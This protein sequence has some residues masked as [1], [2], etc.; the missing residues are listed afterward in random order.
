M[1]EARPAVDREP[2]EQRPKKKEK[3][4]GEELTEPYL[5]R[6]FKTHNPVYVFGSVLL[7]LGFFILS[8]TLPGGI[9]DT[10]TILGLILLQHLFEIGLIVLGLWLI[11]HHEQVEDGRL[12]L[13]VES[14]LL[15]DGTFLT[16]DYFYRASGDSFQV[17][18]LVAAVVLMQINA[19]KVVAMFHLLKIH[20]ARAH[21]FFI[22]L[23]FGLLFGLPVMLTVRWVWDGAI[24]AWGLYACWTVF[25]I[26]AAG[27]GIWPHAARPE[28]DA[29][30]EDTRPARRRDKE[31]DSDADLE[32]E[33]HV[34]EHLIQTLVVCMY[35]SLFA[36]LMA[37]GWVSDEPFYWRFLSPM[38]IAFGLAKSALLPGF[39]D[40]RWFRI[41]QV[42]MP[43]IAVLL[44]FP[45]SDPSSADAT[46][47]MITFKLTLVAAAFAYI[48]DFVRYRAMGFAT[49]A[50]VTV[51]LL[52]L[53][54]RWS[55]V[56]DK[57]EWMRWV[58]PFSWL[59]DDPIVY[60][61]TFVGGSVGMLAFGW[62]MTQHKIR[63]AQIAKELAEK[64]AGEAVDAAEDAIAQAKTAAEAAANA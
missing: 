25:G 33:K 2:S 38:L 16:L 28:D 53:G 10:G 18:L 24:N 48:Y 17:M 43:A 36:H 19:M 20:W 41:A 40:R 13:I 32:R 5:Q 42:A 35:V 47:Q 31:D 15:V 3:A 11:T 14:L 8:I 23:G 61:F 30:E 37:L 59:P 1:A 52:L 63:M 39:V 49:G 29:E 55:D 64:E 27:H 54:H 50:C 45:T 62:W 4:E 21:M 57:I 58:P 60:A 6:Y 56:L 26:L 22:W 34:S 46:F 44:A 9:A 51:C 7:V 12:L